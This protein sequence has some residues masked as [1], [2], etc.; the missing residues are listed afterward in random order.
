MPPLAYNIAK[1]DFMKGDLDLINDDIRCALVMANTDA[2][3]DVDAEV[4]DDFASLD[5]DDATGYA[6]VALASN[7]LV[8]NTVLE[9]VKFEADDTTFSGLGADATRA[10]VGAVL[11]KHITND[12]D[13]VPICFIPIAP[14]MPVFAINIILQWEPAGIIQLLQDA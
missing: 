2:D 11:L 13:S 6:R 4:M 1:L 3:T 14:T 5:E 10:V 8:I 12:T 7:A 9:L